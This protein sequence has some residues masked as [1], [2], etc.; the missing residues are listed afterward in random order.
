M[1][2]DIIST[3]YKVAC[4]HYHCSDGSDKQYPDCSEKHNR[5][6]CP[7][8]QLIDLYEEIEGAKRVA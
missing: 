8:L 2:K 5:L 3:I 6:V 4:Q 1:S 7:A